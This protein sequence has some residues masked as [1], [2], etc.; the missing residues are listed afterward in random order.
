MSGEE[1]MEPATL[2]MCLMEVVAD[3]KMYAEQAAAS[4]VKAETAAQRCEEILQDLREENQR[5]RS[6]G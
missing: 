1:I 6:G 3:M 2:L 5:G 4:V